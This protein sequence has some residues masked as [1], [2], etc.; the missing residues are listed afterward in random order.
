MLSTVNGEIHVSQ[1][2]LIEELDTDVVNGNIVIEEVIATSTMN[3][4]VNGDIVI[5]NLYGKEVNASVV[6]ADFKW[7]D[8]YVT[9]ISINRLNGNIKL[10]NE[11]LNLSN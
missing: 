8:V 10:V 2:E 5:S 9:S 7:N 11:D 3:N 4:I 6:N 1:S